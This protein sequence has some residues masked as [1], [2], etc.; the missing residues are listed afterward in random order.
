MPE[1]SSPKPAKIKITK[2]AVDAMQPASERQHF[3]DTDVKGFGV[4]V[5]P[6]GARLYVLFYRFQGRSRWYRIGRHGSPWTPDAA[7]GEAIRLL[8]DVQ[9]GS[10]PAEAR[11][12]SRKS[13]TFRELCEAYFA[14]GVAH[15]KP[16]TI[17]TDRGR[18]EIHL[19]PRL[20]FKRV[21]AVTRS[22][23]ESLLSAVR[24]GSAL[25]RE[26]AKRGRGSLPKGGDGVGAQCVALAST[27]LEF[28]VKRGLRAD[29]P[30]RGIRKPAVRKME[31]FLSFDELGRL[32]EALDAEF[33]ATNAVYPVAAIR[34]LALT[35]CRRGEILGL[36]W[37]DVDFQRRLLHLRDSKTRE[38]AVYLSPA[39]IEILQGLKPVGDN[40]FV[41]AGARRGKPFTS[42]NQVWERVR[43]RAELSGVRMHDLRH[44]FASVGAGASIGLPVIGKLLGHTQAS[45]T[46]RYAHLAD[47]P[48]RL[49][50]DA[51]G[52]TIAEA[53]GAT[54]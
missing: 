35:G 13:E 4:R 50:A 33:G 25:P 26:P 43:E 37:T 2:R 15:K 31:R 3:W 44:T 47:D 51:I 41:I 22:D 53:M 28:G 52:E 17:K 9:R 12:Q 39:A 16:S 30:A 38:K 1:P 18:A 29:N 6:S 45:T 7:R 24:R 23:I 49:A 48:V 54:R 20:G 14:E 27:I 10:D 46:A 8:G 36:K 11:D 40:P 34:L 21:E 32:A 42:I 5:M 19:I